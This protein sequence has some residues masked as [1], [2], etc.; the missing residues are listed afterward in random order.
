M[1]HTIVLLFMCLIKAFEIQEK[2]FWQLVLNLSIIIII[3]IVTVIFMVPADTFFSLPV[4]TFVIFKC[5]L[6]VS[7]SVGPLFPFMTEILTRFLPLHQFRVAVGPV[8]PGPIYHPQDD[9]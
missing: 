2:Y 4:L 3:I 6:T 1:H 7:W 5:L 8:H 9:I